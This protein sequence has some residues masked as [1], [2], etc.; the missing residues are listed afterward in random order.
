MCT[1][2]DLHWVDLQQARQHAPT[3]PG[4]YAV[5][6]AKT[7]TPIPVYRALGTD[8]AGIRCFGRSTGLAVRLTTYARA[9]EGWRAPHAEGIRYRE[10]DYDNHG[11]AY[12]ALQAAWHAFEDEASAKD[13][14]TAW[15]REYFALYGELPPLNRQGAFGR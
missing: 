10:A 3:G 11:F 12:T 9:A 7:G 2:Q 13:Q 14:E 15:F 1:W 5:R 6:C 8:E 4:A